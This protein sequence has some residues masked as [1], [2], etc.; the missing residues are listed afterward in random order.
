M[1]ELSKREDEWQTA[2]TAA[3]V[4]AARRMVLGDAGVINMNAPVGRLSSHE[5][6][7]IFSSALFA[8]IAV[9][10]EQATSE[11]LDVERVIRMGMLD[12]NPWDA[13]A[14]ATVL[15]KLADVQG[16]D[17]QR[18]LAE[19]SRESM[20]KFLLAALDL[21]R[22]AMVARDLGGRSITQKTKVDELNDEIP[23]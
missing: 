16:I 6:A 2:A 23:F 19:W 14:I 5:W 17:W 1:G 13:G 3:A 21:I 11:G 8:W 22:Q 4:T 18:P 15:P 20:I 12:P 9:R 7:L 10:A